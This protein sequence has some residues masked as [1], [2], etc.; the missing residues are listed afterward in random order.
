MFATPFR[1]AVL[2]FVSFASLGFCEA[3]QAQL[4]QY[5]FSGNADIE[6]NGTLNN[7][8]AFDLV[9]T[10]QI[11]NINDTFGDG[12]LFVN[13]DEVTLDLG[14]L[15]FFNVDEGTSV[16]VNQDIDVLGFSEFNVGVTFFSTAADSLFS[17]YDLASDLS[18]VELVGNPGGNSFDVVDAAG[19]A[20]I[21]FVSFPSPVTFSAAT[22]TAIPEPGSAC[23]LA[24][25]FCG[26]LLRRRR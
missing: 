9:A 19:S 11:E 1:L 5:R 25:A 18:E 23:L 4:I 2:A 26:V 20:A 8:V 16:F 12:L 21:E 13:T 14:A 24:G 3:V 7:L 15:G 22:L 17:S 10:S 6:I